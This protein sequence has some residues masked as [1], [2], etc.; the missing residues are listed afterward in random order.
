M[1]SKCYYTQ[2]SLEMKNKNSDYITTAGW[3]TGLNDM[4]TL[5]FYIQKKKHQGVL[6]M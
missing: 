2:A 4:C 5:Y 6:M 3:L 1:L